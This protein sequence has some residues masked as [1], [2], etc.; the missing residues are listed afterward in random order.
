MKFMRLTSGYS[1]LGL[2]R[3][4][5]ISDKMKVTPIT[6]HV[7]NYRQNWLQYENEW[8]EPRFQNKYFDIPPLEDD[9]QEDER[10]DGW[11]TYQVTKSNTVKEDDDDTVN[12][13]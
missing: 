7:N 10:E 3:N 5:H 9:C 4:K 11:R 1:L 13:L 8:T 6:E 12:C 2:M